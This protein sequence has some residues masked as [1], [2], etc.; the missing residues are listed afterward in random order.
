[1]WGNPYSFHIHF[2]SREQQ[3]CECICT[4]MRHI[5]NIDID[6]LWLIH[7]YSTE[8]MVVLVFKKIPLNH[9]LIHLLGNL[10]LILNNL[11]LL[12]ELVMGDLRVVHLILRVLR[13]VDGGALLLV[14]LDVLCLLLWMRLRLGLSVP[15]PC[16][17]KEGHTLSLRSEC[18]C[19][20]SIPYLFLLFTIHSSIN[21]IR[22]I[23]FPFL[24]SLRCS[25][26][27][28][29]FLFG[30]IRFLLRSDF[31]TL[32]LDGGGGI[33]GRRRNHVSWWTWWTW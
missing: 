24:P 25:F 2:I 21:F 17:S 1:M 22:Y 31:P 6:I 33:F 32:T 4:T 29:S 20:T 14:V 30:W 11:I 28:R 23:P 15:I 19:T 27:R 7:F 5:T 13:W 16:D 10:G 8:G 18:S 3:E 26:R 9:L 12:V